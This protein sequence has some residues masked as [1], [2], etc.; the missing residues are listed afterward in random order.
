M[1]DIIIPMY[2]AHETIGRT[3]DS[4]IGQDFKGIINIYL[5]DD[6]SDYSYNDVLEKYNKL[7][8]IQ[9]HPLNKRSGPGNARN[10]GL[11]KSNGEYVIFVDADDMLETNAVRILHEAIEKNH[12]DIIRSS[13]QEIGLNGNRIIKNWNIS[14]HG[15]IY[16][17]SFID[18]HRVRFL[19]SF[20]NEDMAFNMSLRLGGAK[21]MNIDD[22]TYKW[23]YNSDSI[24][25][26]NVNESRLRDFQDI[27][28][29]TAKVLYKAVD[30]KCE[31]CLIELI[32]LE[33]LIQI[34]IRWMYIDK[35]K[36]DS[37][38]KETIRKICKIYISF[39]NNDMDNLINKYCLIENYN[40]MKKYDLEK[41]IYHTNNN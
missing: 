16:R 13:I 39:K 12:C 7:L 22:I 8:N 28:I 37:Y 5:I 30:E 2:N 23:F 24:Y 40:N 25:R 4:I 36:V 34:Y 9:Y 26:K 15:K 33:Q 32:S 1:I 6:S 17:R 19:D 3:L 29:N 20:S 41:F 35:N 38:V 18:Y 31:S 10:Y 27:T 21:M 14:L 11:D